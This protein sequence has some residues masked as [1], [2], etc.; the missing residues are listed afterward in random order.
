MDFDTGFYGFIHTDAVAEDSLCI[1]DMGLEKRQKERYC[2]HNKGRDYKGYLFQ[3]TLD[4][5]G[6]YEDRGTIYRL[7]KDK[8]LLLSFPDEGSYYLPSENDRDNQWVYFYIHF[9]G[10]AAEV[11][12]NRIR[13]LTG[14]VLSL[15]AQSPAINQ[16]FELYHSLGNGRKTEIYE[17]SEWL[18]RF[19]ISLLK[20]I[21]FPSSHKAN[22]HVAAAAEW[23]QTQYIKS[24]SL[25]EMSHLLGISLAH[26]SREFHKEKGM[27]LIQY[28][29]RTR[30]EHAMY[31]LV[32]TTLPIHEIAGGC[33]FTSSNYFTKVFKKVLS[34]TPEDYRSQH[35]I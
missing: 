15:E 9:S 6:I 3:Y 12:Y 2:Y 17:D 8:A 27:T 11:F 24:I 22:S 5:Y 16:F 21:E 33:G 20:G 19:L 31:L 10:P 32:N 25:E 29:T 1:Q 23:I 13:E 26:L 4:G 30:L 18:Y 14:P 28:L 7:D 34:T 35:R